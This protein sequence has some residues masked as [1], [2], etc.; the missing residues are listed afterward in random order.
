MNDADSE[1][2]DQLIGRLPASCLRRTISACWRRGLVVSSGPWEPT[3]RVS[4][5]ISSTSCPPHRTAPIRLPPNGGTGGNPAGQLYPDGG[6]SVVDAGVRCDQEPPTAGGRHESV[7]QTET[8]D[9]R[10]EDEPIPIDKACGAI[11]LRSDRFALGCRSNWQ[12]RRS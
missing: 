9:V 7:P 8:G 2:G 5:V 11:A 12:Q 10:S 1:D 6:C 3:V 4:R